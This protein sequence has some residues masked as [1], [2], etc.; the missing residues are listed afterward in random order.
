MTGK[1][2]E[3]GS[4]S[5]APHTP[6]QAEIEDLFG[7]SAEE[8]AERQAH[9]SEVAGRLAATRSAE[10]AQAVERLKSGQLDHFRSSDNAT[11]PHDEAA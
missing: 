2:Q 5:E 1:Q 4:A 7:P 8:I 3:F 10:I 6:S 11:S 9:V